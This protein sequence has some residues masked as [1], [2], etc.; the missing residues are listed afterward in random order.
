MTISCFLEISCFLDNVVASD[1][2]ALRVSVNECSFSF[3]DSHQQE[4]S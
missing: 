4:V 3:W 1:R 2:A